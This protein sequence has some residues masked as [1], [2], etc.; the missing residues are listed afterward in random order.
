M[1]R[2]ASLRRRATTTA[3]G[4]IVGLLIFFPILWM[5]VTSFKTELEA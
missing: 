3:A 1:A 5:V 2:A 4:W